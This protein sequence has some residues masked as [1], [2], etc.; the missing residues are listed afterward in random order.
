MEYKIVEYPE[1]RLVGFNMKMS[2]DNI[3]TAELF[4]KLGPR[5]KDVVGRK[6]ED[7][8]TVEI[9]PSTSFFSQFNPSLSFEKWAAIELEYGA[10]T[11]EDFSELMVP[12]GRYAVFIYKGDHSGAAAAYRYIFSDWMQQTNNELDNRPHLS[13]IGSKYIFN[14]P[15][16]EE[17]I[18]IPIR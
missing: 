7:K 9:Y 15:D 1:R 3:R 5:V 4:Q 18:W 8:F 14:H 6:G 16:S 2:F 17:E 11:P 10:A 12:A 13:V